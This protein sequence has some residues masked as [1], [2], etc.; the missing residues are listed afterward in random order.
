VA[1]SIKT[2]LNNPRSSIQISE[3]FVLGQV[4]LPAWWLSHDF[5]RFQWK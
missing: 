2:L 4:A 1:H 5:D 3:F